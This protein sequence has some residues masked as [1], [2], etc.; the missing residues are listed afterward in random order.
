MSTL[1]IPTSHIKASKDAFTKTVLMPGDLKRAKH[2]AEKYLQNAVLINDV[3]GVQGYTMSK[4]PFELE[5]Q[6]VLWTI[7]N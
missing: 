4:I 6:V 1:P 7:F 3:R 2:I 5:Q